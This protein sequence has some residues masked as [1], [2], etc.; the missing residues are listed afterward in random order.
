MLCTP[1]RV[2]PTVAEGI[3]CAGTERGITVRG[4]W[5]SVTGND[6]VWAGQYRLS[7][8]KTLRIFSDILILGIVGYH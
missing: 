8:W 1:H 7:S 2:S 3:L 5:V 6:W 4:E